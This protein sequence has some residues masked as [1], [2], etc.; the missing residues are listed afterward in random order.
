MV[1]AKLRKPGTQFPHWGGCQYC[2][3]L[4][5]CPYTTGWCPMMWPGII[6]VSR[7]SNSSKHFRPSGLRTPRVPFD[8]VTQ[9]KTR[10][11]LI[12]LQPE[13]RTQRYPKQ[14]WPMPRINI[15]SEWMV[16]WSVSAGALSAAK[17]IWHYGPPF[18]GGSPIS[19]PYVYSGPASQPLELNGLASS[20]RRIT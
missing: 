20:S 13:E 6:T 16:F 8:R 10:L 11:I 15:F 9:S 4:C 18:E 19:S 5:L 17:Y 12:N 1:E 7:S 14:Q 2:L 3:R